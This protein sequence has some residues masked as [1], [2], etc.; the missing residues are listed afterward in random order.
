ML[1]AQLLDLWPSTTDCTYCS[2]NVLLPR[3]K[4]KFK[5]Y[6]VDVLFHEQF[7]TWSFSKFDVAPVHSIRELWLFHPFA[8]SPSGLFAPWLVCP[9]ADLPPGLF[10]SWLIRHLACS[11]PCLADSPPGLFTPWLIR[12]CAWLI[13]PWLVRPPLNIPVICYWG[14]C[15]CFNLQKDNK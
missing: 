4:P 14:L 3:M 11:P 8:G 13:A 2:H 5:S 7:V 1:D 9:L 15:L 12:P 6:L 10:T